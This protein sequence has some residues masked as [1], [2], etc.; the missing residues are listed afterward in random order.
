MCNTRLWDQAKPGYT[1]WSHWTTTDGVVLLIRLSRWTP[2]TAVL[3]CHEASR[4]S[5]PAPAAHAAEGVAA[6][7][8]S[9]LKGVSC[10]GVGRVAPDRRWALQYRNTSRVME[11]S[12]CTVQARIN[13]QHIWGRSDT[14]A[15]LA[16]S[17][18]PAYMA[19]AGH[20]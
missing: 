17:A 10:C 1:S 14:L 15:M 4:F 8:P 11:G 13:T 16:T 18:A 20:S 7:L 2:T 9:I 19:V 12:S 3:P 6:R 5:Q